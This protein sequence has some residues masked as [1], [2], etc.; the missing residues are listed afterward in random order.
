MDTPDSTLITVEVG[1]A[2]ST[3]GGA[4]VDLPTS[5][6]VG[7]SEASSGVVPRKRLSNVI[8]QGGTP[9]PATT[10]AAP[11]RGARTTARAAARP[12]VIGNIGDTEPA[13]P[14]R[15]VVAKRK[16]APAAKKAP[17]SSTL[18]PCRRPTDVR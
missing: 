15:N 14:V 17:A 16:R 8:V 2:K 6:V 3:A 4:A 1:L 5:D 7:A 11:K 18:A 10:V 12:T 13:Q 9:A